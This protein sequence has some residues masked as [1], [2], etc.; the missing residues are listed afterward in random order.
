MDLIQTGD[1]SGFS[2]VICLVS[3]VANVNC[4][5]HVTF[6]QCY[7]S[8]SSFALT[9][10]RSSFHRRFTKFIVFII[11]ETSFANPVWVNPQGTTVN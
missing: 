8:S 2:D 5:S 9:R 3:I 6:C 10:G 1:G 4:L 7:V 11:V